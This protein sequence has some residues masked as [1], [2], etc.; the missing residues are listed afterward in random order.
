MVAALP[1]AILGRLGVAFTS[2]W[3]ASAVG[4]SESAPASARVS[5]HALPQGTSTLQ[6]AQQG[7][8]DRRIVQAYCAGCHN[9]RGKPGAIAFDSL[10]PAN[11]RG[12]ADIWE[13]VVRQVR[14]GI[15]P[16][17]GSPR[18]DPATAA[19]FVSSLEARLDE[20]AAASPNPGRPVAHRLNRVEY[21]STIRDLLDLEIDAEALLPA[22]ESLQGFNNLGVVLSLSPALLERYLSAASR[23]SRL[24]VGDPTIGPAFGSTTY[25][26]PQTVFQDARMGEDFAFGTRGGLAVRHRFPLDGEYVFKIRLRRNVFGYTR[27]LGEPHELEVRLD[28]RRIGQF[29][30]GGKAPG[31]PAPLSFTGVILGDPAWEA[32]SLSADANL[33]LRVVVSAGTRLVTV[34]FVEATT[35]A[36]GVGQPPLTGLGFSYDES[37]TAPS[38][39]WSPAID[40][41]AI[42]GPYNATGPGATSS[43]ARI[44]QCTPAGQ[45][46][47]EPCATRILASLARRAYRRP[48]VQAEVDALLGF[49]KQGRERGGFEAGIRFALERL[50]VDPNFLFRIER[51]PPKTR[52][53]AAYPISDL[54]LASR[55]S[56]FLWSSMPDDEL[57]EVAGDGTLHDPFVLTAQVRRMLADGRSRALVDNFATG[58]LSLRRLREVTPD[59]E[60][61]AGFDGNLRDAFARETELFIGSQLR[62]DKSVLDLLTS[63]DTFVNDRL[64]RSYGIPGIYGSHFRRITN[65]HADRAGLLGQGSVLAITSYPTRTS[66]V[67]RGRWILESL[68]GTPPPSPPPNIP[69]LPDDDRSQPTTVRERMERHRRN[70]VCA[71]CHARMDP[72]GFTLEQFDAVGRWRSAEPGGTRIDASGTLPDGTE[73]RGVAGL[74]HYILD[75]REEFVR[76]VTEKLLTYALGRT[77]ELSDMPAVRAIMREAESSDH[78][79]SA[80]ILGIVK[81]VPFQLRRAAS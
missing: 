18:P 35:E 7:A 48:A 21:A 39:P 31:R 47:E 62:E 49:F 51:D 24:A 26:L 73:L 58:W 34:S 67:L 22:D 15:M 3:L 20:T 77:L 76:T 64:A 53:G 10:D 28:G 11:V 54:E 70:P 12:A 27:G 43:R 75:H 63:S 13:N 36:E 32:Y 5:A 25:D 33:N 45:A 30:V 14:A 78:R 42:E 69:A 50:L 19:A 23:I 1:K 41:L 16:P 46:D 29:T 40:S 9:A 66:P 6:G 56:F 44:L 60:I 17:A 81:S 71:S 57:L 61:F 38:G 74:R 4:G 52:T 72:L 37:R 59:P 79:W 8:R 55:L 2:I 68:L 65:T 80:I